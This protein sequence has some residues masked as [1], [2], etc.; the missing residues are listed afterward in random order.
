MLFLSF[1]MWQ[2]PFDGVWRV[3]WEIWLAELLSLGGARGDAVSCN[4]LRADQQRSAAAGTRSNKGQSCSALFTYSEGSLT[5]RSCLSVCLFVCLSVAISITGCRFH[6]VQRE[7]LEPSNCW[8]QDVSKL[9][10]CPLMTHA[11]LY[12]CRGGRLSSRPI[13]QYTG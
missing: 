5:P 7:L 10:A 1:N 3:F 9:R 4:I 8:R 11:T 12:C 2:L 13:G 6:C